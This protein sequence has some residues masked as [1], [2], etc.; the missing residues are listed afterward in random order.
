MS[1]SAESM[2]K[3]RDMQSGMLPP[4]K[5]S[6]TGSDAMKPE[7]ELPMQ[8]YQSLFED[9]PHGVVL[10]DEAGHVLEGNKAAHSLFGRNGDL[11][12][13]SLSDLLS[14]GQGKLLLEM[15]A[16]LNEEQHACFVEVNS[17]TGA[18]PVQVYIGPLETKNGSTR[19]YRLFFEDKSDHKALEER[20]QRKEALVEEMQITLRNVMRS[21]RQ[22]KE[23]LEKDLSH[24][25]KVDILPTLRRMSVE[26]SPEVRQNYEEVIEEQ[27]GD[28]SKAHEQEP[29]P[30]FYDLTPT[31]LKVCEY[32]RVGHATKE[33]AET[34]HLAFETV[35]THRK[36]IRR[37]LGLKGRKVSLYMFLRSRGRMT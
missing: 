2:T 18:V 19:L 3:G 12:G 28:L 4:M 20:L 21:A 36:N 17:S 1:Q 35:Q 10:V 30:L 25:I 7:R 24:F 5:K 11:V 32:I 37:K 27:L 23:E 26:H 29:D 8:L 33:I 9:A 22:D 15:L 16:G 34:M 14:P 6:G 31:E 13:A